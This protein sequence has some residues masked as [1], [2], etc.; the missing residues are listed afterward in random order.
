MEV[1]FLTPVLRAETAFFARDMSASLCTLTKIVTFSN[2]ERRDSGEVVRD[3]IF[4]EVK[5]I[6]LQF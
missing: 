6:Y 4:G 3:I 5:K 2:R 1:T